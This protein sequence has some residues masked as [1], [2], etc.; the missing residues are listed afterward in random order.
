MLVDTTFQDAGWSRLPAFATTA[1]LAALTAAADHVL[2]QERPPCMQRPGNDLVPLRWDDAIVATLLADDRRIARLTA[3]IAA[4]DL[5]WIS[6]YVSTKAPHSPALWWHQDWWCWDHAVSYRRPA[7]QVALLCYLG[8]TDRTSGALRLLPGTHHA[9]LPLHAVL[10][11]AHGDDANAFAPS[12]QA[13]SDHPGQ[14]TLDMTAGDAVVI[15]YRLLHGTHPNAR[16]SRRDCILLSFAP[17]WSGLPD[18]IQ[19]HLA[20]HPALPAHGERSQREASE[21]RSLLPEFAGEPA[22]LAVNRNAPAAFEV[23]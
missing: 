17:D 7:S 2:A 8:A 21:Y 11:E 12:H 16:P 1:E 19:A 5:K 20:M 10:P 18:D 9:S 22:S 3:A 4:R 15:D 6:A 13:M 23:A 14:I